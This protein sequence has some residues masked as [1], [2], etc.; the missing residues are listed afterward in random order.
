MAETVADS[1]MGV[2]STL[3]PNIYRTHED[4]KSELLDVAEQ[5]KVMLYSIAIASDEIASIAQE[6]IV[7]YAKEH[8]LKEKEGEHGAK[9]S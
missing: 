6:T 9:G 3:R 5:G 4:Q 2:E 8:P 7:P 1:L